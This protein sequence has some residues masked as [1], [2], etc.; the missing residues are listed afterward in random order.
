ML[1]SRS[2]LRYLVGP[3]DALS[4]IRPLVL[5][6]AVKTAS[7]TPH[8]F[9]LN[10]L[11]LAGKQS[12]LERRLASAEL[13]YRLQVNRHE[14]L[15]HTFFAQTNT[16]YA[17]QRKEHLAKGLSEDAFDRIWLDSYG[18]RYKTFHRQYYRGQLEL[19]LPAFKLVWLRWRCSFSKPGKL[20]Q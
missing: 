16:I 7:T 2:C 20:A 3:V 1:P 17:H 11:R 6:P 5:L 4:N 18:Q 9:T 8:S 12:K 13:Q 14:S 10:E 19:L 15:C